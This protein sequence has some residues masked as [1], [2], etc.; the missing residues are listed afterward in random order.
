MDGGP[1]IAYMW[2]PYYLLVGRSFRS[3]MWAKISVCHIISSGSVWHTED[4][5][6]HTIMIPIKFCEKDWWALSSERATIWAQD[7]A[8][9]T[10]LP[11]I[12]GWHLNSI[13][14][15][16]CPPSHPEIEQ[17]NIHSMYSVHVYINFHA[18]ERTSES[19]VRKNGWKPGGF[20]LFRVCVCRCLGECVWKFTE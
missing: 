7:M 14:N 12:R 4:S 10:I 11:A 13:L 1:I 20:F 5:K 19:S 15:G 17:Q 8:I 6:D 3:T 9:Y 16:L 2:E 18:S